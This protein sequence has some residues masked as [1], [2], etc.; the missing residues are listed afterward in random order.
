MHF[1][2][3]LTTLPKKSYEILKQRPFSP[4]EEAIEICN[5]IFIKSAPEKCN[6][7]HC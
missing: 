6:S 3:R 1:C 2:P 7:N 5:D 4:L